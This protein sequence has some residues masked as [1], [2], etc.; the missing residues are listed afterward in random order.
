[1]PND[2]RKKD[3]SAGP[4]SDPRETKSFS[5]TFLSDAYNQVPEIGKGRRWYDVLY[6]A[7]VWLSSSWRRQIMPRQ[8]KGLI[9]HGMSYLI[10]FNEHDRNKV[11]SREDP[12]RNLSVPEDE[13]VAVPGIWVV[14]LFPP[15]E[16]AALR[17]AIQ[18]NSW[19]KNRLLYEAK[20][21]TREVLER[22]RSGTGWTWWRLAEIVSFDSHYLTL[23]GRREKLPPEFDAV[24]LR[25][26]QIGAGLTV[27]VALFQLAEHAAIYLDHVWRAPHL[28][29]LVHGN[30]RPQASS[31][32]WTAFRITQQ[33]RRKAHDS[34]RSWMAGRCGGFFASNHEPQLLVDALL[35]D[36][37]DPIRDE[38]TDRRF[39]DALRALGLTGQDV[40][41]RTSEQIPAMLLSPVEE[42]LCS[43]LDAKRTWALWGNRT[44][45]AAEFSDLDRYG[46]SGDR[47]LVHDANERIRQ[48]LLTLSISDFLSVMD[49]RYA[50]LRDSARVRHGEFKAKGLQRLRSSFLSL[51]LDLT[52]VAR[53]V[54][55]FRKRKSLDD[56]EAQFTL[57]YAPWIKADDESNGRQPTTPIDLNR[58]LCKSQR[59]KF[60]KLISA[61]RDYCEILSTVASLGSSADSYK[62]SRVALIAAIASLVVALATLL[63]TDVGGQT[64]LRD[65]GSWIR[66]LF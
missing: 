42:S 52:S 14:E 54:D 56:V 62:I 18:R 20:D 31:S 7:L 16:F 26:I 4:I 15:S 2:D 36:R 44:R 33:A 50:E 11:W 40:L 17:D 65:V 48:F 38:R 39:D 10:P 58:Q 21:G 25:A 55:I 6:V 49:K 60:K 63:V 24:E 45:V 29:S 43:D 22:S 57:D 53:D 34:A 32:M 64:V 47:A 23:D 41:H 12:G 28:P 27:V 66:A 8:I 9:R 61:D 51:S 13:H 19:G 30:G 59:R 3:A 37:Y 5:S 46:S 1:M 35:F